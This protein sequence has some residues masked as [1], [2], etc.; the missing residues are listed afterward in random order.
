[1]DI[2]IYDATNISQLVVPSDA[3]PLVTHYLIPMIKNG[4][5]SYIENVNTTLCIIKCETYILPFTLTENHQRGSHVF[6]MYDTF[7]P[8][9]IGELSRS[10][11][12]F[13]Y[14]YLV[15]GIFKISGLWLWFAGINKTLI[16]NNYLFSTNIFPSIPEHMLAAIVDY[17]IKHYKGYTLLIKN[18]NCTANRKTI[19][20]LAKMNFEYLIERPIYLLTPKRA[21]QF[22]KSIRKALRKDQGYIDENNFDFNYQINDKQI[23]AKTMRKF[24]YELYIEKYDKWNMLYNERFF[25]ELV[26]SPAFL[27]ACV[28][29][30]HQLKGFNVCFIYDNILSMPLIGYDS[31]NK[32]HYRITAYVVEQYVINHQLLGHA[33]SG[34]GAFKRSRG[35]VTHTEYIAFAPDSCANKRNRWTW[36]LICKLS[37]GLFRNLVKN[38]NVL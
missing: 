23:D 36:R 28:T 6:S 11:M 33:S 4:V 18:L 10:S 5:S 25:S 13:F 20:Q 17:L 29:H 37:R 7:V 1:M 19:K 9:A 12:N 14:K 32:N 3:H 34:V 35:Y 2:E 16:L 15:I 24:Y 22:T 31:G 8:T 21:T 30:N 26:S 27:L 38:N